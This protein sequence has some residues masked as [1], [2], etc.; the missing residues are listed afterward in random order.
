[1]LPWLQNNVGTVAVC[2]GL[3]LLLGAVVIY[4]IKEKKRGGGCG[5]GCS[6]CAMRDRCHQ[7][8]EKES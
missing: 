3:A 8:T 6:S 7:T 4:M 2:L 5:C 1:M